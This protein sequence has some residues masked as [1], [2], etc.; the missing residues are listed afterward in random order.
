[1]SGRLALRPATLAA[2]LLDQPPNTFQGFPVWSDSPLS[3]SHGRCRLSFL[4]S[5]TVLIPKK[6]PREAMIRAK[7]ASA[8]W[9]EV[10]GRMTLPGIP[11]TPCVTACSAPH[12]LHILGSVYSFQQV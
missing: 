4:A 12:P 11:G 6:H 10:P 7:G 1:M 5:G 2:Y 9:E 3:H 8:T